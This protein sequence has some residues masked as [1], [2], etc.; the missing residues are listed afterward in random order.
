MTSQELTDTPLNL[1]FDIEGRESKFKIK[2]I[3]MP[4]SKLH[5]PNLFGTTSS[6]HNLNV[7]FRQ[8]TCCGYGG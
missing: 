5:T 8:R 3:D 1:F 4:T 6:A 7:Y 2:K